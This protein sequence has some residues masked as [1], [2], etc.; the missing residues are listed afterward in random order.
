MSETAGKVQISYDIN[1]KWEEVKTTLISEYHYS[2]TVMNE[3]LTKICE[4]PNTTLNH[5]NKRVSVAIGDI[6]AVCLKHKVIL[7]RASASLISETAYF[8]RR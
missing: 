5:Q 8:D 1:S 7:E 4:L 6:Q 2:D 3:S